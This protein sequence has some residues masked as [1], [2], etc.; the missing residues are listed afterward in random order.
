MSFLY[1]FIGTI[2]VMVIFPKYSIMGFDY[3]SFLWGPMAIFT[4][5]VNCLLFGLVIVDN[6]I[7]SIL[8][9]Q[10]P[11]FLLTWFLLYKILRTNYPR[12]RIL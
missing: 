12:W 4:L 9:L 7:L 1:V 10:T 8:L 6:S 3:N 11:V 2:T 5:P